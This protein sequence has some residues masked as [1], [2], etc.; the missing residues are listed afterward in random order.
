MESDVALE[1]VV[2]AKAPACQSQDDAATG[3][4]RSMVSK[5][6]AQADKTCD[7]KDYEKIM[8]K[9][10]RLK[11]FAERQEKAIKR[12]EEKLKKQQEDAKKLADASKK[13]VQACRRP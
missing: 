10:K 12:Q 8:A 7:G 11:A 9:V 3:Q 4:C 5:A 2:S 1:D 6:K 13:E